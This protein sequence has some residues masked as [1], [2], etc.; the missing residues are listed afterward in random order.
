MILAASCARKHGHGRQ[1]AVHAVLQFQP[2][3]GRLKM[4]VADPGLAGG[5]QHRVNAAGGILG[6]GRIEPGKFLTQAAGHRLP[7]RS[8]PQRNA[9]GR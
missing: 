1:H 6:I 5:G 8:L 9:L 4:D 7:H 3:A 2:G